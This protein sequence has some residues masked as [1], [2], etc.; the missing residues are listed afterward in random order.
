[1][2]KITGYSD[3]VSARPGE[4]IKFMVNCELGEYRAD[5]VK[6]ICGDSSPD[7]PDFKEELIRTPANKRYKGRKQRIYA[8][9]Y[10]IVESNPALESL[11]S[12]TVQAMIW[13]TTPESGRQA[14]LGKWNPK[15]KS[16]FAMGIAPDGSLGL[17]LGN[18][19]NKVEVFDGQGALAGPGKVVALGNLLWCGLVALRQKDFT[20][21]LG[22]SS[23]AHMGF[24]FLGIASLNLIGITGAVLVMIAHGLLAALAFGLAGWLRAQTGTTDMEKLG[25][26]LQSMPFIGTAL[27]M[28]LFAGCG[29]PGFA[30]F[31]GE[32]TIFFAAWK[33]DFK[34]IAALAAWAALVVGA[35]YTLRAA[36]RLLHGPLPDNGRAGTDASDWFT[37]LPYALLLAALLLFGFLPRL[38]TDKISPAAERLLPAPPN[39]A[40][41]QK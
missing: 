33:A 11:K 3:R 23:V 17:M 16:G 22:N 27:L 18:G 24:V 15:G 25:G 39:Q 35:V 5:I 7:G 6:L 13:P 4:T 20:R 31:A 8:G 37:K 2:L 32:I 30:N 41:Q 26:L 1:M 19:R 9:S 40:A 38:L 34:V 28:A 36:R 29:L 10:G 14:I 12:F 21:M